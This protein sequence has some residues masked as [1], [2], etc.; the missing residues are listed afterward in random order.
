MRDGLLLCKEVW[1]VVVIINA[2]GQGFDLLF[3]CQIFL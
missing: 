2:T 3:V 1:E